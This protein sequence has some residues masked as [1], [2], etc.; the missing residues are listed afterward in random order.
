MAADNDQ[1]DNSPENYSRDMSASELADA[2][3]VGDPR[4]VEFLMQRAAAHDHPDEHAARIE[5]LARFGVEVRARQ[6]A[7]EWLLGA[8]PPDFRFGT[9]PIEDFRNAREF[10]GLGADFT[11]RCIERMD[12]LMGRRPGVR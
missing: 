9:D 10:Q 6:L 3:T 4:A 8:L 1:F 5:G 2:L 12:I 11:D 7:I